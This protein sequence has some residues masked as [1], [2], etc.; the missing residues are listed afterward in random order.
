MN[1]FIPRGYI[2]IREALNHVGRE[3]FPSE[4]TGEEHRARSGLIGED[5]WSKIKNVPPARGGG[6]PVGR[7]MRRQIGDPSDPA[8]QAEYR[9]GKRYADACDRLRVLLEAG[10]CEVAILDPWNGTLHPVSA[11]LWRRHDAGRMIEKGQARIPRSPNTGS[12][13]IKRFAEA[14][15]PPK[16]IAQARMG[17]IIR[18]LQEKTAAERLTRSQ[19]KAFL[20]ESFPTYRITERHFSEIF[21]AVSVPTGRPRKSDKKV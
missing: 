12:L 5:E 7:A 20:R 4:W 14:N 15:A 10:D 19:Q 1:E 6:E 2:S 11:A 9:A 21:R 18:A 8:Y 3:L 16:P 17:D 13:L